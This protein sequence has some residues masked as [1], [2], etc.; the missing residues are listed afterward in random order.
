MAAMCGECR[1]LQRF[2]GC[3]HPRKRDGGWEAFYKGTCRYFEQGPNHKQ[4]EAEK[5]GRRER[6]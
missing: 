2:G 4:R 3:I 5:D 6:V 1:W